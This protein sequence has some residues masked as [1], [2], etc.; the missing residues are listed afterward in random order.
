MARDEGIRS[1]ATFFW[2]DMSQEE[3]RLIRKL[4]FFILVAGLKEELN[5]EGSQYNVLL[6]MAS[7]GMLIGQIPSSIMI[8]KVRPRIWLPAMI[9]TWAGCTMASAACT[10][11]EQLCAVRFFMGLAEASTYA[12]SVYIMGSW[13][14]SNELAKRTAVFTVAGQ[15]G[16]M[17]AGAMMAAIHESMDGFAG[18]QGWQWVFL[19]DGIMTCP[20][21]VFGY[22]YFPDIPEITQA[23]YLNEKERQLALDRLPPKGEDSHNIQ[24]LSLI[25]RVLG[26]P[27][28]Y[29]CCVFSALSSAMQAYI[30]QGLMLLYMKSHQDDNGFTQSQ[31]NT[32]PI[33]THAVGIVAELTSSFAID[34][35]GRRLSIGF[36]L[37]AIQIACSVVLLVPSMTL[38]G[39]LTAFYL[40]STSYGINPLLY[41]WSSIIAGYTADDAARS[42]I[43]A[44]MAASDGL[45]WTFWGIVFYPA[46]DAPY[47]RTGYITIICVCTILCCWLFVVR[48]V[49]RRTERK[50]PT[51]APLLA[52][53]S[54]M[55]ESRHIS[56]EKAA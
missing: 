54:K 9:I 35:Y 51:S 18:L 36:L 52:P 14:K 29:V 40:S 50:H 15:V 46:D 45:L 49:D 27:I 21:A 24:P 47:W 41:S 55:T 20:V 11:F 3:K 53:P 26:H 22:F 33:P 16:K 48:W 4:D 10:N 38:A 28:F 17:F 56:N 42:V 37:C 32:Y 8:Q 5:L 13:Y 1:K 25:K 39:H 43:L 23:S 19:I 7:A 2:G 30:V 31:I 44:S 34:R 12:G 6:S